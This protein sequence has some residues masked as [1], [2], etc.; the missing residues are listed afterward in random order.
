MNL[1]SLVNYRPIHRQ[2]EVTDS[3]DSVATAENDGLLEVPESA[4]WAQVQ[5]LL[6]H[7]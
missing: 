7:I 2:A 5:N 4:D 6:A 1:P 3:A